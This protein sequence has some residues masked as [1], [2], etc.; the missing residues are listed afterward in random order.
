MLF[1]F[2]AKHHALGGRILNQT[3]HIWL[4]LVAIGLFTIMGNLDSSIVNIALPILAHDFHVPT[5]TTAYIVIIYMVVMSGLLIIGGRLGDTLGK[6]RVFMVG[7]I[8]F[9]IGS[10]LASIP[11]SFNYLLVARVVQAIGAAAT[12]ANS[13]GLIA[14]IFPPETRGQ[15]IGYNTL[16]ISAGFIAG[17]ALGGLLLQHW[18]WNSIFM[19]NLP[20]GVI[21]I[22]MGI[23]YLPRE[24]KKQLPTH[25]DWLGALLLFLG[26]A[27]VILWLE[28]GQSRG[29]SQPLVLGLLVVSVV[30]L[31]WFSWQEH[32]HTDPMLNLSLFSNQR[33]TLSLLA[34]VLVMMVNSFFDIVFP[35]YLENLLK[36]SVGAAGLMMIAFPV[37]MAF[38][39]PFGGSLGDRFN[40]K[41]II[42]IGACL[43]LV[44]QLMYT[45]FGATTAIVWMLVATAING[46]GTGLFV[47]NNTTLIMTAIPQPQLGVA[48]AVQSLLTNIGQVLG[49]VLAN[50]S[51][52][53]TMSVKAGHHVTTISAKH[54]DWFVAGMH[55]AFVVTAILMI[56]T[57]LLVMSRRQDKQLRQ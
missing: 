24:P 10:L 2:S 32:H 18:M 57:L 44:A 14:Q 39:A 38:T 56:L 1:D 22:I 8:T 5:S 6:S 41:S 21:A 46:I 51:L 55:I 52:Y 33:F 48:G 45:T 17:P 27:A 42:I 12:M 47:S 26:I 34:M 50:L 11:V 25:F 53:L 7:M 29:F 19:I 49:V 15:A 40:R 28:T 35:F 20:I 54:P 4:A 23:R 36:W 13:Y 37:V 3:K 16:F 9:T 31:V 43:L 30:L